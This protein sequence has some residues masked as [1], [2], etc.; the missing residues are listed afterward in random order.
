[1]D[2]NAK[3]KIKSLIIRLLHD[4][5]AED[6]GD[7]ICLEIKKLAPNPECLDYIYHSNEFYDSNGRLNIEA[8]LEKCLD[9][10]PIAL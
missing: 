9:H 8:V 3:N 1:M 2:E 7:A 10:E 5:L 6:E 4:G